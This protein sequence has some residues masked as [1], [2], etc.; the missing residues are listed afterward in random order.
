MDQPLIFF[1]VSCVLG[2]SGLFWIW[3]KSD[4]RQLKLIGIKADCCRIE[5]NLSKIEPDAL[6]C[7][8]CKRLFY[9]VDKKTGKRLSI[10]DVKQ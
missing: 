4:Q 2:G 8:Y 3:Y 6:Q 1:L 10:G 7:S 9:Y 5:Y